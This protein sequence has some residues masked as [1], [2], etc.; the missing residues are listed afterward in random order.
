MC[1]FDSAPV[2]PLLRKL[3]RRE[4]G[5]GGDSEGGAS[6]LAGGMNPSSTNSGS[7]SLTDQPDELRRQRRV[8]GWNHGHW[9]ARL[10]ALLMASNTAGS[11]GR[12]E[13][14]VPPA[15]RLPGGGGRFGGLLVPFWRA[16][17]G[18]GHVG[19]I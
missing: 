11:K 12:M 8:L 4:G 18:S 14:L 7:D 15:A 19:A 6:W 10:S 17:P 2:G 9:L 1:T 3:L 13:S 5:S 16:V